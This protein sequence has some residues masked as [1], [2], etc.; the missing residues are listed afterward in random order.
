MGHGQDKIIFDEL[1]RFLSVFNELFFEI[2]LLSQ[3][4]LYFCMRI[5]ANFLST[6][7]NNLINIVDVLITVE[8]ET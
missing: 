7:T 3:W 5:P 8:S 4:W 2:F 6:E 1:K